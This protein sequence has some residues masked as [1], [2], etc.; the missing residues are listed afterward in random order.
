[1]DV[2]HTLDHGDFDTQI[3]VAET[4]LKLSLSG[5]NSTQYSYTMF[6]SSF[7]TVFQFGQYNSSS[8]MITEVNIQTR[9]NL[10]KA[11][12][13]GVLQYINNEGFSTTKGSRSDARKVL[14]FIS[15][16]KIEDVDAV[17]REIAAI[18]S[19]DVTVVAV[20]TGLQ[21][22]FTVLKDIA[23]DPALVFVVGN[24]LHRDPFI[25]S[26][27]LSIVEYEFCSNV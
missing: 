15:A 27:M 1:M 22:N 13:S 4:V 6:A 14:V 19:N 25:M 9:Y 7:N 8:K 18:K 24:E 5:S 11:Y 23:S 21:S 20:G 12:G 17:R 26:S 16:G 10:T 2:S 3:S